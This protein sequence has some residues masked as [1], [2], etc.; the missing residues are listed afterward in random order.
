MPVDLIHLLYEF[1]QLLFLSLFFALGNLCELFEEFC[2]AQRFLHLSEEQFDHIG[3]DVRVIFESALLF[4]LL[5]HLT[6]KQ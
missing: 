4:L 2:L 6:W 5:S 3:H 1:T